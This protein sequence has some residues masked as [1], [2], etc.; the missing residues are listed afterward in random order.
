MIPRPTLDRFVDDLRE[1]GARFWREG[2]DLRYRAPKGLFTPAV[3]ERLRAEKPALLRMILDEAVERIPRLPDSDRYPLSHAQR[4]FWVLSQLDGANAYN[5]PLHQ[6]LEGPLDV[7]ALRTAL[8]DLVERHEVL[9]TSIVVDPATGEPGQVVHPAQPVALERIDLSA[10]TDP[11]AAA[12]E[13]AAQAAAATFDL[14]RPPLFRV[15]LLLVGPDRHLLLFTVHHLVCDG[16]SIGTLGR[17]LAACYRAARQGGRPDLPA[18]PIQYRDYAAWQQR[19]LDSAALD[20][21]RRYWLR[22]LDG[23]L[24]VLELPTDRPRPAHQTYRGAEHTWLLPPESASGLEALAR[25]RRASLF[26]TLCA[27]VKVLLHRHTGADDI[28]VATP[29]GGRVHPDLDDQVGCYLNILC[30]RDR[31]GATTRF[32]A[33]LDAVR[34]TATDAFDHQ[35]YPFDRLVDELRLPRDLSR[36]PVTDVVVILQNQEETALRLDE[37]TGTPAFGHNGTSKVDLT[38]SFKASVH[39]LACGIEYNTDLFTAARITRMAG[40]LTRLAAAFV[41][42]PDRAIGGVDILDDAERRAVAAPAETT[43]DYPRHS[44][45]PELIDRVRAARP[46]AV[47]VSCEGRRVTYAELTRR[48]VEVAER[49]ESLGVRVGARVGVHLPRSAQLV[50]V[51]LG[52]LRAGAAYVPLDPEFPLERR[53]YMAADAGLS[54]VVADAGVADLDLPGVPVLLI[55]ADDGSGEGPPD[56]EAVVPGPAGARDLAYVIYT[57][58]STGRPKGVAIEH[59]ALVNFLGAMAQ[60]TG[61]TAD[62]TLLAVTTLS[63]DIAALELFLPLMIGGRIEIATS[64][65]A[66]DGHRLAELLR[67]SGATVMQATPATWQML[68]DAGWTGDAALTAL[69]GGEAL[70]P[71]LAGRLATGCHRV[72]N[73]YG[74]TETTVWSST[75]EVSA[76]RAAAPPVET[77]GR[78]AMPIG[79]EIAN[80]RIYVLDPRWNLAPLGVAGEIYIGGDG[81]ARGYWGRPVLTAERFLPDPFGIGLG[82]RL[83]RTGDIGVRR[84]DGALTFHG[85]RDDQVKLRGFRIETAE[86]EQVLMRYP[87]V[88]Q[89]AVVLRDGPTGPGLL[90]ALTASGAPDSPPPTETELRRHLRGSVP[91]Y[92][93]PAWWLVMAVLPRTANGKT[94]RTALRR[95][96]LPGRST[97]TGVL[98]STDMERRIA[99]VWAEVLALDVVHAS[100]NFFELGGHSLLAGRLATRVHQVAGVSCD[101]GDIFT[102]PTLAEL[103]RLVADRAGS[104]E[105]ATDSAA[106]QA[107]PLAPLTDA[108]RA[109]LDR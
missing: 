12:R 79:R 99:P 33:L 11:D 53:C 61:F 51:L 88:G 70:P 2:G 37:L 83:Y 13:A 46:G 56:S 94:D 59:R 41:D 42:Q 103:A 44:T 38:F 95:L 22:Q 68:F 73:L 65:T 78:E 39:G 3:I 29:V 50:P 40:H 100:A 19:R 43:T 81:V 90:A 27:L 47:A 20:A 108:E 26:M 55:D 109:L 66:A 32:S 97:T 1:R 6:R 21:E 58:G 48:A 91:E 75:F 60:E 28:I 24:P 107:I 84:D 10:R 54:A 4:R 76:G 35:S 16:I 72:L 7:A 45:L 67:S 63:F 105:P 87:G 85:R 98:P 25:V 106:E 57:S 23:A 77:S 18:L 74:P 92:M 9:R 52:I 86:I 8:T 31:V 101:L 15:S 104:A 36:S 64:A 14:A 96:P 62:D 93:V 17:D 89:V 30:L 49:L 82:T 69:C 34:D 102:H 5:I 71:G 80:T